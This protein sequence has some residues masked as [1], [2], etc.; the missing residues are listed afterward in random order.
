MNI[1]S[2]KNALLLLAAVSAV[3]L[4]ASAPV[5]GK[6]AVSTGTPATVVSTAG[7]APALTEAEKKEVADKEAA[8]TAAAAAKEKPKKTIAEVK[9]AFVVINQV[10]F[11]VADQLHFMK[12]FDK[13]VIAAL[14]NEF[15]AVFVSK[16]KKES[17]ELV[18]EGEHFV[19]FWK[20]IDENAKDASTTGKISK[21]EVAKTKKAIDDV[22]FHLREAFEKNTNYS[23]AD[24]SEPVYVAYKAAQEAKI[25]A[26]NLVASAY[27]D[28]NGGAKFLTE[29]LGKEAEEYTKLMRDVDVLS[30]ELSQV[31]SAFANTKTGTSVVEFIA[32]SCIGLGFLVALPL[33]YKGFKAYMS[34]A[35]VTGGLKA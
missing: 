9:D 2:S 11:H 18:K 29:D 22:W 28:K 4:A 13:K 17:S 5:D 3:V 12:T 16:E 35:P 34:D 23:K 7:G 6:T 15:E 31:K 19:A 20:A 14:K 1:L 33:G 32:Y 25:A 26:A 27:A 30:V 24:L 10:K 21:E 8:D